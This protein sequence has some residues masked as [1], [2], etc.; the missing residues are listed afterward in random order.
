MLAPPCGAA[1][2]AAGIV[3]GVGP[4]EELRLLGVDSSSL[5]SLSFDLL[6]LLARPIVKGMTLLTEDFLEDYFCLL[7]FELE[8]DPLSSSFD[9]FVGLVSTFVT[10]STLTTPISSRFKAS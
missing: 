9:F 4:L 8:D 7:P 10:L 1:G 5:S 2:L 3:V 6:L